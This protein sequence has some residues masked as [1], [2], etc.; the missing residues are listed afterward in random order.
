MTAVLS[1]PA[2]AA[3]ISEYALKAALTLN[4]IRFTNWP[5]DHI[6]TQT[7]KLRLCVSGDEYVQKAFRKIDKKSSGKRVLRV[8]SI[9][10]PLYIGRCDVLFYSG[11][12]RSLL[13]R[14]L[15]A[16][17]GR[18]VLTIGDV[19]GFTDSGGIINMIRSNKKIR[20]EINQGSLNKTGLTVS[21]K[22]LKLSKIR[23][24]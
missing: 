13:A 9:Q 2:S 14:M 6:S 24:R 5:A 23:K 1:A 3:G 17:Q 20:F 21:S 12:N 18:P 22:L 15:S 16:T 4:F 11:K 10:N 19:R 7:G 8:N